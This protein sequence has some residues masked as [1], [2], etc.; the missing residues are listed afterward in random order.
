MQTCQ[1]SGEEDEVDCWNLSLFELELLRLKFER[2][3]NISECMDSALDKYLSNLLRTNDF[4]FESVSSGKG[5][6]NQ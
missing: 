4:L 6:R 1:L 5:I 3:D 2:G